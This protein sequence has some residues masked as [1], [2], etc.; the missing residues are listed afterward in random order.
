MLRGSYNEGFI[1][2]S[3]AALFTSPRWTITAGAGDIDTYRNPVTAEGPYVQRTYFGGNPNL[4]PQESEGETFGAVIDVPAVK[5]LSFTAYYWKIDRS[6]L[7]GRRSVAQIRE[8]D[9]ALLQAYTR[10][11]LASGVPINQ[12]DLGSGTA[13]YRGDQDVERFPLTAEG[14]A[15]FAA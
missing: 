14:A 12:I 7:L 9:T 6:D 15:T 5:G 8:S 2:P 13:S 11:Q 4:K 3:L 1:A 10:D